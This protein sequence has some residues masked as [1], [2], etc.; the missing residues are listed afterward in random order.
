MNIL[1]VG[2]YKQIDEWG[3]RSR[4]LLES[5]KQTDHAITARPIYLS[6]PFYGY[7][8]EAEFCISDKYDA[9]I[10]FTMPSLA[11]YDGRCGKN[12]GIFNSETIYSSA[13]SAAIPH[14]D[15]MDE[16]W[17][18]HEDIAASLRKRLSNTQVSVIPPC[19]S[20][21]QWEA[22]EMPEG[23][24]VL[25]SQENQTENKFIFY[26]ICSMEEKEGVMDTVLAYYSAFSASDN[27]ALA[28]I[29]EKPSSQEE[30][31]RILEGCKGTVG[32]IR[33]HA[34]YAPISVL[35]SQSP[36][37]APLRKCIHQ[38]ADCFISNTYS[39]NDNSLV[40]EAAYFQNTP[41]VNKGSAS[42][43]FL[44][45]E[46]TWGVET[47]EEACLLQSRPFHDILTSEE[48][49]RKPIIKSLAEVMREAYVD[50]Y[51]RDKKRSANAKTKEVLESN[52]SSNRL[53]ELLCS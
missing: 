8:E 22:G 39:L 35:N 42:Y 14:M 33:S 20:T 3:R 36:I 47:Y 6:P 24:R 43:E 31:H 34:D 17:V 12:I 37:T 28:L 30:L 16:V 52:F 38:E 50:K 15:L 26:T 29:I 19:L 51:S 23:Y 5:L 48:S 4:G 11:V 1:F 27:V 44:H 41:V 13:H 25:R 49:W 9:V 10:Q 2:P 53:G 32:A 40:W 7:G 18:D 45:D 21:T 46:G